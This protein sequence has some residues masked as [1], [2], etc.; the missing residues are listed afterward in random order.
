MVP[1]FSGNSNASEPTGG[2]SPRKCRPWPPSMEY[3][4]AL[5]LGVLYVFSD[6]LIVRRAGVRAIGLEV[7]VELNVDDVVVVDVELEVEVV[8]DEV[9]VEVVEEVVIV[10]IVEDEDVDEIVEEVMEDV[11]EDVEEQED[12]KDDALLCGIGF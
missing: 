6:G 5:P 3:F 11:V 1:E 7:V 4:T 12:A 9:V 2:T 8:V 10:V